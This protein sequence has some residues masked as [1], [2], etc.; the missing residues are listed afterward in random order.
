M[1]D[2]CI[3]SLRVIELSIDMGMSPR[4]PEAQAKD[5]EQ[6]S[7]ALQACVP[8]GNSSSYLRATSTDASSV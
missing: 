4:K 2:R 7:L 6:P 5:F 8:T 1:I 3:T